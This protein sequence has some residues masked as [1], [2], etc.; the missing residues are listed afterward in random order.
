MVKPATLTRRGKVLQRCGGYEVDRIGGKVIVQCARCG[1]C[2][3][4]PPEGALELAAVLV[5]PLGR[6]ETTAPRAERLRLAELL[7]AA[8]APIE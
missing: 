5:G 6:F 2:G 4:F 3:T 8:A 1:P 7:R